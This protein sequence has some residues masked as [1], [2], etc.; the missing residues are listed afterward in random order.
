MRRREMRLMRSGV[1]PEQDFLPAVLEILE[2]PPSPAGRWILWSILLAFAAMAVWAIC[3]H[4]DIVAVAHGKIIPAGSIKAVQPAQLGIVRNL[5]VTEGQH[6]TTG[7]L[8]IE[9]DPTVNDA[10][11]ERLT[12]QMDAASI[13][14]ERLRYFAGAIEQDQLPDPQDESLMAVSVG[15]NSGGNHGD[16]EGLQGRILVDQWGEY[17]AVRMLAGKELAANDAEQDAGKASMEKLRS[18]LPLV[19]ERAAALKKMIERDLVPKL[20]WNEVEQRRIETKQEIEVLRHR[21][22]QLV[23]NAGKIQQ[24]L[25]VQLARMRKTVHIRI[26]ELDSELSG[27]EQELVKAK[28]LSRRQQL[29]SPVTG[30]VHQVAVHTIGGVV[31]PAEPLMWIVPDDT[32]LEVEAWINNRDIGFVRTDDAVEV[33]V[34]TFPFTKYGALPGR[35]AGIS[36]DAVSDETRGLV[37]KARILLEKATI[38]VNGRQVRLEPGM[39]VS[40][41][42]RTGER[43]LVEFLMSPLLRYR[44]EFARER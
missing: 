26:A 22:Q 6:V 12:G 31:K 14:R 35:L 21:Q 38:G 28:T 29:R 13:E 33:K 18:I 39:A 42:V 5:H 9:L 23:A 10:D 30:T 24:N 32:E 34:E 27:L 3:G 17:L 8:L 25:N 20:Q 44:D 15:M 40:A 1:M 16:E 11:R 36:H 37:Y 4:V 41:E 19:T 43:R 2:K 7:E